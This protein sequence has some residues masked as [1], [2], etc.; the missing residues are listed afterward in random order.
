MLAQAVWVC[1]WLE[2]A[3]LAPVEAARRQA[4]EILVDECGGIVVWLVGLQL[5]SP[6][7]LLLGGFW[8]DVRQMFREARKG[9]LS[10]PHFPR[11]RVSL[12][13]NAHFGI[14]RHAEFMFLMIGET[15]LQ[16][17]I[18]R[19]QV[20]S[21]GERFTVGDLEAIFSDIDKNPSDNRLVE[22][23]L[24][25]AVPYLT[26]LG[27]RS[28]ALAGGAGPGQPPRPPR[29]RRL[30]HRRVPHV[31][32][33]RGRAGR[34]GPRLLVRAHQ[35]A[36]PLARRQADH[37]PGALR[38][39]GGRGVP[40]R[41]R[42]QAQP[43]R[44]DRRRSRRLGP[45]H[46]APCRPPRVWAAA[47][48]RRLDHGDLRAADAHA[49]AAHLVPQKLLAAR[50]PAAAS[51]RRPRTRP[52]GSAL[53]H[54]RRR[55]EGARAAGAHR[56]G[57]GDRVAADRVHVPAGDHAPPCRGRDAAAFARGEP[58]ADEARSRAGTGSSRA[59]GQG[60]RSN[61]STVATSV[62]SVQCIGY[63]RNLGRACTALS[64]ET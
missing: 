19:Q 63:S 53:R 17:I 25:E 10:G 26:R 9:L 23:E 38:A 1:R 58:L 57:G 44:R 50:P 43:G 29:P 24:E 28:P 54:A 60:F 48:P 21:T 35:A 55:A 31:L 22:S 37:L 64:L 41:Y 39:Q 18:A 40:R 7:L 27:F 45:R 3:V 49:A 16:M 52:A 62:C 12:P 47:S 13:L 51:P 6:G 14:A 56:T 30:P 4:A 32:A 46:G 15:V 2:V 36:P 59:G 5:L 8:A 11:R 34:V 61:R 33:P 20:A 42:R